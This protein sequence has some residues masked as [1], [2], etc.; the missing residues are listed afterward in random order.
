MKAK[1][2][3]EGAKL[4]TMRKLQKEQLSSATNTDFFNLF[5]K[6]QNVTKLIGFFGQLV[7]AATEFHF[8]F[9]GS[10]GVYDPI[11]QFSNILPG[12]FGL[13][14]VY[15]L[16]FI[17]VRVYLVRIVRQ[18]ANK[19]FKIRESFILFVFNLFF[20]G[21]L[22]AANLLFSFIGQKSTFATKTNVTVTDKTHQLELKKSAKIEGVAK[23]YGQKLKELKNTYQNDL[24]DLKKTYDY[25]IK[26]LKNSRYT[27][28]ED[29]TKYDGYTA[30]IDKKI[31][32]K[33]HDLNDLKQ[34]YNDDKKQLQQARESEILTISEGFNKRINDISKVEKSNVDLWLMVQKYTLPILIL[35]ILISWISIIYVEVFYKGSG[36]KIEVKEVSTRPF[37]L[38]ILVCGLY[39]KFYHWFYGAVARLVGLDK[40]RYSDIRKNEINIDPSDLLNKNRIAAKTKTNNDTMIRQIGFGR[41]K[42]NQKQNSPTND[43][44][45]IMNFTGLN[46]FDGSPYGE[47]LNGERITVNVGEL[48]D[49]ERICKNCSNIFTYKHWNARYCS[50]DCRIKN[51]EKRTGKRLNKKTKK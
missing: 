21:A 43:P 49:N 1:K 28:R 2:R 35:F 34:N 20:V 17:G 42:S 48:K 12:V 18:I 25:D 32:D 26:E 7:S 11:W 19:Q 46:S 40:Y 39:D 5:F 45:N 9:A 3:S 13:L 51:W 14:V 41:N 50:D 16:E 27:H 15:V 47:R 30:K 6:S 29:R 33:T 37:L 31:S 24:S 10:G 23:R 8:V 38:W 4:I 22:C 36:Q 44:T